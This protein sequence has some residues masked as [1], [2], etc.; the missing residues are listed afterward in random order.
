MTQAEF[1]ALQADPNARGTY[2]LV[3][4]TG[5]VEKHAAIR[6]GDDADYIDVTAVEGGTAGN[7]LS[8]VLVATG[9][10]AAGTVSVSGSTVTITF[11]AAT[12]ITLDAI[13]AAI[14]GDAVAAALLS[15]SAVGGAN[16]DGT[17]V[18]DAGPFA[19]D[20]G[21]DPT[22]PFISVEPDGVVVDGGDADSEI[23][24]PDLTDK[25]DRAPYENDQDVEFTFDIVNLDDTDPVA[26]DAVAGEGF[27]VEQGGTPATLTSKV[28][29]SPR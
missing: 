22:N 10:T 27:S 3:G 23:K 7:A 25:D 17:D 29:C 19:L 28:W 26:G 6:I 13:A 16:A 11:D 2:F 18:Q 5:D 4:R 24:L 15:V 8:L 20:G 12:S 9:G 14:T 1:D 21:Q